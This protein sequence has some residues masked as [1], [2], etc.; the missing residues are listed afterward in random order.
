M[1]TNL[2]DRRGLKGKMAVVTGGGRGI[3]QAYALRLAQEGVNVGIADIGDT[4]ETE[5]MVREC[6]VSAFGGPCDVGDP[7][8]VDSF[9]RSVIEH[10]SPV[11][12]LVN[13]AGIYPFASLEEMSFDEWRKVL[14]INLDSMFIVTKAFLPGMRAKGWGRIINQA[15]ATF[16]MVVPNCTHYLASKMGVIG[17]TRALASEVGQYG[18][19]VNA[20]A[21]GATK[22]PGMDEEWGAD[23]DVF[24][25]ARLGQAIQRTE[26]PVDLAGALAFLASND[27]AFVTG[28]TLVVDGGM[29]R[30]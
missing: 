24:S 23:A 10:L 25:Q 27:A 13:N 8:S 26:Q 9:A 15:S 28:Q 3:G 4:S 12:I 5:R 21:P 16:G 22:T 20:I 17:F 30:V 7:Q 6:G 29:V 18:I 14:A 2:E 1:I 11:D 19:T